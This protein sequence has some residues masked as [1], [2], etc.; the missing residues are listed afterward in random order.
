MKLS[1]IADDRAFHEYM[2]N[3]NA[4]LQQKRVPIVARPMRA[5]SALN[6]A[7]GG[8]LRW[9][10]GEEIARIGAWYVVQYG[11]R[12]AGEPWSHRRLLALLGGDPWVLRVPIIY[13][14]VKVDLARMIVDG[15][16]AL[17]TRIVP[18]EIN[19][20]NS[21]LPLALEAF[22][23]L[24]NCD[25]QLFAD[26]FAAVE[27]ATSA[28]TDFG[29]SRWSAQQGFEKVIKD[30]IRQKGGRPRRTHNLEE[31]VRT[32]EQDHGLQ[33]LD[34]RL[35]AIVECDPGARYHGD[36]Q[37]VASTAAQAVEAHQ[38]SMILSGQIVA[39]L[40][41]TY[42]KIHSFKPMST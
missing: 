33:A 15:V 5:W 19:A 17:M 29:M 6:E 12:A 28:I 37:S 3:A 25:P 24:G 1:D 42:W 13:G 40:G 22:N 34:R 27:H 38:A 36:P 2:L 41:G 21:V 31:L 30:F 9:L 10:D 39:A 14:A 20:L 35:L 11:H 16:P 23:A 18:A 8:N 32:A 7:I 26:W 4:R